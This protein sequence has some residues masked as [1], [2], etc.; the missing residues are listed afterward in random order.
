MM[1][2]DATRMPVELMLVASCRVYS[3]GFLVRSYADVVDIISCDFLKCI[4]Y[5][6][7]NGIE[8]AA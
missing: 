3:M 4:Y 8:L 6:Y 7:D 1:Y 5:I 2:G